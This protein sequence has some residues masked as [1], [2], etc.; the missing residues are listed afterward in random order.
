MIKKLVYMTIGALSTAA[1]FIGCTTVKASNSSSVEE[2]FNSSSG[3]VDY[4]VDS[5]TG[6]CYLIYDGYNGR[7]GITVRYNADG[8]IMVREGE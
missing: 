4:F 7:G 8:T 6:V 5:E 1:L 3:E 2:V